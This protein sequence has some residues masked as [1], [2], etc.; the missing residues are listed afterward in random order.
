[1]GQKCKTIR[2]DWIFCTLVFITVSSLLQLIYQTLRHSCF[3]ANH[4]KS[5]NS[6]KGC[7]FCPSKTEMGDAHDEQL[8]RKFAVCMCGGGGGW[9]S[10]DRRIV[11]SVHICSLY[12]HVYCVGVNL[13][14]CVCVWEK[15][16]T[17]L[18]CT[19][20][21][22]HFRNITSDVLMQ[23]N[24]QSSLK[25]HTFGSKHKTSISQWNYKKQ[26]MEQHKSVFLVSQP[27]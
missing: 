25:G 22:R 5:D 15:E 24:Q 27:K 11:Q 1:M 10:G 9:G 21:E 2:R 14:V 19:L 16:N 18:T 6:L 8:E 12:M 3:P 13:R 23:I 20:G 7:F 26:Q 17:S 4:W